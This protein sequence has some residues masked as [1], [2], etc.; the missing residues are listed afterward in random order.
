MLFDAASSWGRS[1]Y[2]GGLVSLEP[3]VPGA[4][5]PASAT[6]TVVV[7]VSVVSV[8]VDINVAVVVT[9]LLVA[10]SAAG[11]VGPCRRT[12]SLQHH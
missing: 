2:C 4:H 6:V 1:V 3:A 11:E 8:V 12:Q 9:V 10:A 5:M 7:G